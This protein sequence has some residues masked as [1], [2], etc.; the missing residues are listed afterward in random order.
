M[1]TL[2]RSFAGGEITP[3]LFGRLDLGKFQ[4]GLA[5]CLNFEI[6]PHGPAVN[7]AGFEYVLETKYSTR[8]SVLLPFIFST[9]QAYVLEF[10]DLYVRIHT[11]GATVLSTG[12][13][14]T[15][16]TRATTN[17]VTYTGTDPAA[18]AWMYLAGIG[19]M[20]ELNGRYVKIVNLN[21]AANTFEMQDLNG[22]TIDTTNFTAYTSGGTASPVYEI[23]SPYAE[24]DLSA[25]NIT[26][27]SDVLTITHPSYQTRELRR[28]GAANW[29]FAV[30]TS[31]PS[32]AAPTVVVVTPD[33]AGAETY[34]Y[35]V[36]A[37]ATD[38]RE[39]SL[40][41]AAGTNASCELLSTA[42]AFNTVTWTDATGAL[43]YNVYKKTN[44]LYGYIGQSSDGATGFKDD[45]ITPDVSQTPP[46]TDDPITAADNRPGAVGYYQSRRWFAGSNNKPQNLWAT[47]SGT[48]S[49][50]TYSVPTRDSDAITARLTSR[51]AN[52]IRHLIPLGD[53]LALTS[54]AEWL[55]NN[56]GATGPITPGNIDYRVQG[57][58]GA[59][60]VRPVIA[61]NSILYA[62]DR[63]GRVRE[64]EFSWQTQGYKSAD[65]SL[66]APHLFDGYTIASMAFVRAPNPIC[67]VVR[68]DGL[69]LG[70]TYVP[71]QQVEA[72]HQHDTVDGYFKSVAAIPEGTDD[73]LYAIV[74]RT[75]NGLEKRYVERLHSRRFAT[76][77]DTFIVDSGLSYSGAATTSFGGFWHLVGETISILADGAVCPA[78]VV[79]SNGTVT[80]DVAASKMTGGLPIT[81]DFETLPIVAEIAA[82][83]QG[84]KKNVNS[85][86]LRIYQSS[87]L[88]V[89]PSF[90]DLT[91]DPYRTS[92]PYGSPPAI[93]STSTPVMLPPSW[94][95]DGPVC[96]RQTKPLP[97]TI[98][99]LVPDTAFGG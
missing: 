8:E 91:E 27:S 69:L 1:K 87:S 79:A 84:T 21:A 36:T 19:G 16:I 46:E 30:V 35:K 67:W 43:R 64:I 4:T 25:L 97:L 82:M 57:G 26:Q 99:G 52:T 20:T 80:L 38:G 24:A 34:T 41:S 88:F 14:I 68:S 7:R 23:V 51:Q 85:V 18:D 47:R 32:Q 86:N 73:V 81:A 63:G 89:G 78:Q 2:L 22:N 28:S 10:G 58:S 37:I 77:A 95:D 5:K 15:A 3:E 9:T 6:R 33:S 93:R 61:N 94:S 76:L 44:G 31:A 96:V 92:E 75:I 83:A 48:E 60:L 98:I 90:D 13:A 72:W 74:K 50:F 11:E 55:I 59:S 40:G 71:E 66:M 12:L 45:N 54:G 53:L 42:G 49:N 62:A 65:I 70:L 56:G 29:A 17:S 39:E